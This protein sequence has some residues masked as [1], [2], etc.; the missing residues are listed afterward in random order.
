MPWAE[1]ESSPSSNA[2]SPL[3]D[4]EAGTQTP[5]SLPSWDD[6]SNY[7]RSSL[8]WHS[9]RLAPPLQE[10]PNNWSTS[11]GSW[12]SNLPIL[13]VPSFLQKYVGG[14]P[15]PDHKLH[16]IAALDGL[17]GWAC[18]LVFN[19]HFLFTYTWK[20]AIGWGFAKENFSIFQL[21]IIHL[22]TSGH[23]MVAIFFVISGYVLSYKPLKTIRSRSWDQTFVVLASSTFRRGL[24]L[25][26]PS[27]IG[28]AIVMA[29][30][31]MGV[32]NYS[33]VVVNEGQTI[34]GTN[35][36][37]PIILPTFYMQLWDWYRT[38]VHLTD[39]WNWGLY[40]NYYN[41]HLWTIPVEFRCSIVLF[42]TILATS[43]LRSSVRIGLVACLLWFCV[44]WGRWDVVLF[45]SGMLMAEV[46]LIHGIWEN[47]A[48]AP[49]TASSVDS[50]PTTTKPFWNEKAPSLPI[51]LPPAVHRAIRVCHR[52]RWLG[53]FVTGLYIGSSPNNGFKWTPGYIWLARLTPK[54][55]PE[56]HRFPQTIGA[57]LIVLA[58]N[59]SP[60]IQRLF[61]NPFSQY[62][63]RIS[64]AFY[65]V[66]GPILHSLGYSIM[67]SIWA[68]VGRQ[69]DF[70]AGLGF[71]LG[72]LVCL[73]ISICVADLFWRAVDIPSVR[74]ARWLEEKLVVQ[75]GWT[76]DLPT[77]MKGKK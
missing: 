29:A 27:I 48:P 28:I 33:H 52:N 1:S 5:S 16:K 26:I 9:Q 69:T 40:Y 64:F 38:V 11:S 23:I 22:L 30:V 70:Q 55:Y 35:E 60:A 72:W 44:R 8:L 24:R 12:L 18:L 53:V 39:P 42:L 43:R 13:I 49:T 59:R 75:A 71:L 19:F 2:D 62:L 68:V 4:L 74:F 54:T 47:P 7:T 61:T 46:D 15:S 31:R 77:S 51:Q 37:H 17:R 34:L 67:P 25:Y 36:Q 65:I 76:N 58:I 50:T 6:L 66:H 20:V 14:R 56:P 45:L 3:N 10:Y 73:P 63:G 41:P 57:V 21:P 32:Y